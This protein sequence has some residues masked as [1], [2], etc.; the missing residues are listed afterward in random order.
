MTFNW[1]SNLKFAAQPRRRARRS[2]LAAVESLQSRILKSATSG[3]LSNEA[4]GQDDSESFSINASNGALRVTALEPGHHFSATVLDGNLIVSVDGQQKYQTQARDVSLVRFTGSAGDDSFDG[5]QAAGHIRFRLDGMAGNDLLTGGASRDT[6]NG[7]LGDDVI[8]GGAGNDK[9]KGGAGDDV[10]DGGAGRDRLFGGGGKDSLNGGTGADR[11]HGGQDDDVLIDD[12]RAEASG[13]STLNRLIGGQGDD[14]LASNGEKDRLRGGPGADDLTSDDDARRLGLTDSDSTLT[15]DDP[16]ILD[17]V[18]RKLSGNTVE[19]SSDDSSAPQISIDVTITDSEG[20]EISR[21]AKGQEFQI[22]VSARDL[23]TDVV[24][25]G[26]FSAYF[27]LAYESEFIDVLSVQ[28]HSELRASGTI[29]DATGLID[30]AGAINP[31][32]LNDDPAVSGA[33]FRILTL[34]AVATEVTG[35]DQRLTLQARPADLPFNNVTALGEEKTATDITT[36]TLFDR[37]ELSIVDAV[38]PASP[39]R[40]E[41]RVLKNATATNAE[42]IVNSLPVNAETLDE[43]A[44]FSVEF[45][46]SLPPGT[47]NAPESFFFN[48][49]YDSTLL[50]LAGPVEIGPSFE[51]LG[52]GPVDNQAGRISGVAGQ[53]SAAD[54]ES[55]ELVLLARARFQVRP[56]VGVPVDAGFDGSAPQVSFAPVAVDFHTADGTPSEVNVGASAEVTILPMAFDLNDDGAVSFDDLGRVIAADG[57]TQVSPNRDTLQLLD[58]NQDET[59][60]RRDIDLI[61][62]HFLT[63][64]A[65]VLNPAATSGSE[66]TTNAAARPAPVSQPEA[67]IASSQLLDENFAAFSDLAANELAEF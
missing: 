59:V 41:T 32:F 6:I 39:V 16:A 57:Q 4:A 12:S 58:F 38:K 23:R 7:G 8:F 19:Q 33:P 11:L 65:G 55:G 50:K 48:V 42:G 60:D 2:R 53:R 45:Y 64:N 26:V 52:D 49:P 29:Q 5:S 36:G 24:K 21:V 9:L 34:N 66:T 30:E 51:A 10:I 47:T 37:A 43:S 44:T 14:V 20:N 63:R 67:S 28:H 56:E 25:P 13:K 35:L 18:L 62:D 54:L 61:L 1:L 17:E 3:A 27:D 15:T 46:G 22:H 40:I 31:A